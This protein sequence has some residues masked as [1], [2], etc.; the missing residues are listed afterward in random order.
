[1]S[2]E[3]DLYLSFNPSSYLS[4]KSSGLKAQTEVLKMMKQINHLKILSRKKKDLKDELHRE[5]D[6]LIK[7]I[8]SIEKKFPTPEIPKRFKDSFKKTQT[9]IAIHKLDLDVKKDYSKKSHIDAE[10][11]EI[12]KKLQMLNG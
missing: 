3:E 11:L 4:G 9:E 7:L 6:Q 10:L 1:M 8:Y 5:F 12:Q 2:S